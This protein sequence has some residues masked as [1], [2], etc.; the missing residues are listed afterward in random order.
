MCQHEGCQKY[1]RRAAAFEA[2]GKIDLTCITREVP[3][4]G[5][6]AG[7][8]TTVPPTTAIAGVA[9]SSTT[10]GPVPTIGGAAGSTTTMG[11]PDLPLGPGVVQEAMIRL[12][13]LETEVEELRNL[14]KLLE[15]Q[16][17]LT[18]DKVDQLEWKVHGWH[19]VS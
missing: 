13:K 2:E 5:V 1:L 17:D 8:S 14:A 12:G 9:G 10:T 7:G 6:V 16:L 3:T 15:D 4:F 19:E 11:P 18:E